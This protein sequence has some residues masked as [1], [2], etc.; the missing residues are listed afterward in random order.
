VR[1]GAVGQD[2]DGGGYE[3]REAEK[4]RKDHLAHGN[5]LR[6]GAPRVVAT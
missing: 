1:S 3:D 4:R 5:L 6:M 2:G